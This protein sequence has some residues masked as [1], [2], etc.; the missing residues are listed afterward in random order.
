MPPA[1]E[2]FT[3]RLRPEPLAICRLEA[4]ASV[5]AWADG[6]GFVSIVRTPDELSVVCDA[7]RVPAEV[8]R[9]EGRFAF[10]IEGVVDFSTVGVLAGLIAPLAAAG[11]S[12]YVVSTYDTD[13]VLVESRNAAAAAALWRRDGHVV[14][15]DGHG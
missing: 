3:L 11:I 12:V 13:Y 5:P 9:V 4:S 14:T 1:P 2:R 15:G 6:P 8:K 7:R 10:G